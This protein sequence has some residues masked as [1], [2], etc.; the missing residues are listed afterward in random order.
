MPG[1][2]VLFTTSDAHIPVPDLDDDLKLDG[3]SVIQRKISIGGLTVIL[4]GS[5][6]YPYQVVETDDRLVCLDGMTYTNPAGDA[7]ARLAS[8]AMDDADR[9][10]VFRRFVEDHDGDYVILVYEKNSG[11]VTVFNDR[12]GRL[13]AYNAA[14]DD[15]FM[16]SRELKCLLHVKPEITLNRRAFMEHLMFEYTLEGRTIFDGIRR[17]LPGERITARTSAE[18]GKRLRIDTTAIP[19]SFD[20]ERSGLPRAHYLDEITGLF[21]DAVAIRARRLSEA[22][23]RMLADISGGFDSRAVLA[24]LERTGVGATYYTHRLVTGDESTIA[25]RLADAFGATLS[26][27]EA[28]HVM[29]EADYRRIVYLSD[30]LINGWSAGT[31][32]RDAW[33]KREMVGPGGPVASFMGFGGEFIRHPFKPVPGYHSLED[34]FRRNVIK[35]RLSVQ[36]AAGLAGMDTSDAVN[37]TAEYFASY[38]EKTI[39]GRLRR[40][41]FEYYHHVVNVGEDR[42]RRLYWTVQPFWSAQLFDYEM[43]NVPLEAASTLLFRDF[44]AQL[45]PRTLTVPIHGKRVRLDS[46]G[47]VRRHDRFMDAREVLRAF[48]V[49]RPSA[50]SVYRGFRSRFGRSGDIAELVARIRA[51]RRNVHVFGSYLSPAVIDTYIQR[52]PSAYN[53]HCLYSQ[54]VFLSEVE[55]RFGR[56]VVAP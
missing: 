45:D 7:V 13:P 34:M 36:D 53:L 19:F 50:M 22:G 37:L 24:G 12:F 31:A 8:M 11:C 21:L 46:R 3:V 30:G 20:L 23:Y 16:V 18:H 6:S 14:G 26:A 52:E 17:L 39:A 15:W 32:W 10:R 48:I 25:F 29:S 38:P 28:S 41:Y 35:K 54:L 33:L 43:H 56:K 42:A 40:L 1:L 47:S 2:T 44:L 5:E 9:D 55:Q 27:V 51:L 4:S 49:A